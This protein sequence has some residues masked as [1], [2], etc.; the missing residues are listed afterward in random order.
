[1]SRLDS[2]CLCQ[3][4]MI[5]CPTLRLYSL[6]GRFQQRVRTLDY[7]TAMHCTRN[8]NGLDPL[9]YVHATEG[10]PGDGCG[11]ACHTSLSLPV[12]CVPGYFGCC[13]IVCI[14]GGCAY[15]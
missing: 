5:A 6:N 14:V 7:I 11:S 10:V 15:P 9:L 1:M 12:A 8:A 4:R 3:A 13:T 2:C